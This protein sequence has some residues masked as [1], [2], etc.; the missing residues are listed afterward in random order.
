MKTRTPTSPAKVAAYNESAAALFALQL[1]LKE[2]AKKKPD[3][4]LNKNKVELI[5]NVLTDLL[6]HFKGEPGGKYLALL[7]DEQLPQYGDAVLMIAQF[8]SVLSTFHNEH[9]GWE[10]SEDKWFIEPQG[11]KQRK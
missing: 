9:H 6:E 11:Q 2:L 4:T 5:N 7:D 10:G 1:E 8:A 3:A